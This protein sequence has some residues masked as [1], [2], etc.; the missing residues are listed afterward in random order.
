MNQYE[1]N[2]AIAKALGFTLIPTP[3]HK[4]GI[5]L[6]GW[7]G[8]TVDFCNNWS[9]LMPLVV[10]HRIGVSR[11]LNWYG[12]DIWNQQDLAECLLKALQEK[13]A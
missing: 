12:K 6:K 9:D 10:E 7:E 3:M 8:K 2:V 1:V 5:Q 11:W 4:T 13:E